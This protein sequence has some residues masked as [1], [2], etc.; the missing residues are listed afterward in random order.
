[1]SITNITLAVGFLHIPVATEA[2]AVAAITSITG[3][4]GSILE[5]VGKLRGE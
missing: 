5:G 4:I 3:G 2:A 1:L